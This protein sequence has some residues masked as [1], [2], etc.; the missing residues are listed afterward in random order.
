[1]YE[2]NQRQLLNSLWKRISLY[3]G[4]FFFVSISQI[5]LLDIIKI[6]DLLPDFLLILVCWITLREGVYIGLILS[7]MAGIIHDIFALNPLG[8]T[9]LCLLVASFLLK[10]IKSRD[11]YQ[12]DLFTL[13]FVLFTFLASIVASFLKLTLSMNV[14]Q[15]NIEMYFFQQIVGISV[16]TSIFAFFPVVIKF[17][18]KSNY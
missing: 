14:L 13:R 11:N 17:K 18:P 3:F 12:K 16:Y 2:Y 1:M 8:F 6:Q 10:F 9:G 7:F 5:Y 15:E 4:L